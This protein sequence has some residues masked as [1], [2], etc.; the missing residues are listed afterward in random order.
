MGVSSSDAIVSDVDCG[1]CIVGP[2]C[3]GTG[4]IA[5]DDAVGVVLAVNVGDA[6]CFPCKKMYLRGRDRTK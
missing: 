1:E 6:L 4:C 2:C 3:T 5:E